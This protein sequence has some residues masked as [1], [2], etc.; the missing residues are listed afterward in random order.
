MAPE[1]Q[2]NA[3][4]RPVVG[5]D[6]CRGGWLALRL[7]PGSGAARAEIA[8]T[9]QDVSLAGAAMVAVDMPVGL[10]DAGSRGCDLA[11]RRLLPKGRKSSVFPAPRRYMLACETW[12]EAQD[13]G[14][15]REGLGLS[16]QS[17]NILPKI[18]ELDAALRPA[19]Q[20]RVREAHP[21][22]I[23]HHLNGWDALPGK[24]SRE[25]RAA[26]LS[27]LKAAGLDAI[28]PLLDLYPRMRVQPDDILDAAA[29]ALAARRMLRGEAVCLPKSPLR[30]PRGL[31]ME[32]W[33]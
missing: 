10:T 19:D 2:K 31:R 14:R 1:S 24:R 28:E 9:W 8:A 5:I 33:Y 16:K 12:R 32:I 22:L 13:E 7:G 17:W 30:D 21:E 6:G 26:R 25:G 15:R 27:I 11:A 18:R 23:F 20:A 4:F 3:D 29:C